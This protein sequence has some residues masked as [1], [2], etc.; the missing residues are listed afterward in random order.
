MLKIVEGVDINAMQF[1]SPLIVLVVTMVTVGFVYK[2]FFNWLPRK[3]FE[4][5]FG[6]VLLFGAYLWA[7]PMNLGFHDFFK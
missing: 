4:L 1:I 6:P 5:L 2:L 3:M 7:F